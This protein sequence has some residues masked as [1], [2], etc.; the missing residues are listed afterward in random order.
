LWHEERP[1]LID[2]A[3]AVSIEHPVARGLLERDVKNFA[4]YLMKLGVD[5]SP[6]AF[7]AAVGGDRVGPKV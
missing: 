6:E 3:Q 4:R 1:V 7:F 2:V 5:T